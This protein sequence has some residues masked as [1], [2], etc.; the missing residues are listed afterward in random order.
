MPS[1]APLRAILLI[2][3]GT[4][5]LCAQSYG[6]RLGTRV[7]DRL[8]YQ[9]PGVSMYAE[10]LEPR[11]QRW[12]LPATLFSENHRQQWTYTNYAREH[13]AR[14]Q[15]FDLEGRYYY[16]SFGEI[17][18]QGWVIYDWRQVQP[19][20]TDSSTILKSTQF[21]S[22]F[23]R[24]VLAVDSKGDYSFSIIVGDELNVTLTP[25]TFR[26]AGFNGVMTNLASSNARFTGLFSRISSPVLIEDIG[27]R[28]ERSNFTN[29]AAGRA[30]LDLTPQIILG[31]NF[32]NSH[33]TNGR[34]DSFEGNPLKGDLA[35]G[36]LRAPVRSVLVKLTDDSPGDGIGG[37]VLL[38]RDIEN[39]TTINRPSLLDPSVMV[40]KDTVII[41]S[42]AEFDAVE[43]Q[44]GT[45]RDGLLTA[46]GS[47]SIVLRYL[48]APDEG[49]SEA[50]SLRL[51]LQR[52]PFNMTLAE[53]ENAIAS[54]SNVRFRLL[55]ANDY[56]V[57]VSSDQQTNPFDV[58]QF[59]LV[60]RADGNIRNQVNSREVVFDYGLPTAN[61][62]YGLTAEVRDVAGFDFY[63][64]INLN[65]E[66]R[67]YPADGRNQHRAIAG[68]V[69]DSRSIG[70]M[71]NLSW[72]AHPWSVSVEGFGM[73]D[74]YTTSVQPVNA[75]G[76]L[77]YSPEATNLLYDYVDDNDDNDRHPDQR[78]FNQGSLVPREVG[79]FILDRGGIADPEVFP[80]YDENGDFISDFNQNDN[81]VRRNLLP[82]YDEPFL[83]FDSDRPQFL[84]GIDLNNNNWVD[85]F[86]NDNLPDYPYKKDHW[87][88][89]AN[90]AA[91][92]TPEIK[93]TI[94]RLSER[95]RKT[96]EENRTNYSIV[97]V[98][99]DIPG[100]GRIR[101]FDMLRLAEDDI[102]DLLFQ[103][104]V[105]SPEFGDPG[106]DSGH[107][108]RI[109]D[110][111]GARD[112]WINTLYAD[113]DYQNPRRW[114]TFHRF[115]WEF[116]SQ[117]E[118]TEGRRTS[119]FF[120]FIDKLE[121]RHY[122]GRV[123][124]S[125]KIK[126]EFLR[127]VPFDRALDKRRSWDGLLFLQV[128]FPVLRTTKLEF[129][130]E[131]RFFHD[132]TGDEDQLAARQRTGDFRGTVLAVQL[133]NPS[134]YLGYRLQTQ[135][136]MRYDR[137]SLEVIDRDREKRTSGLFF[138]SLFAGLY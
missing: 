80:G 93:F 68:V 115:K 137:R 62:L 103:W 7:G 59:R 5:C 107:H 16:D 76:V 41:G 57:E 92:I 101:L 58:P 86:E 130:L 29:L 71:A 67:K 25:M 18:T 88:Y 56:R 110:P 30:E 113:W 84:F 90:A 96:D 127:E 12:Y 128:G 102:P 22:W 79:E 28:D 132:L 38:G 134:E 27:L 44:G 52:P 54:I 4:S 24:Q 60:T 69:G 91:Q 122:W 131:Q 15:S 94:G 121:Y 61:L 48:L 108:E 87:G 124:I 73:D 133:T 14:Y 9:V 49:E 2:L 116:W 129:G 114:R 99:K 19:R 31:A 3:I 97:T 112:T 10:A 6:G 78:R 8:A 120:G 51:V 36:Q 11:A 135:V 109:V 126:S 100:R 34:R 136:G 104:V 83:R 21:E 64:E 111:L 89:N 125:P 46:N 26:K 72:M 66:H 55:L 138:V 35:T 20:V 123:T 82:D 98:E 118:D 40:E 37:A 117:R 13:Y 119:G 43:I 81:P 85:R 33:T 74:S 77:D 75:T 106:E 63:G 42:S 70:W 39:T 32:V 65:T 53:A 45:F 23:D 1:P 47:E 17:I 95:K 105:D 50:G